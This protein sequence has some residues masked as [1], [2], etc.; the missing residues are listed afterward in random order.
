VSL[1]SRGEQ[2]LEG[3]TDFGTEVGREMGR[4]SNPRRQVEEGG[5]G[6]ALVHGGVGGGGQQDPGC[7][8]VGSGGARQ[9]KIGVRSYGAV[10]ASSCG[11][12]QSEQ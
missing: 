8:G 11:P 12:V 9:G 5:E 7:G 3:V 1:V 4:G 10:R 2:N 6:A